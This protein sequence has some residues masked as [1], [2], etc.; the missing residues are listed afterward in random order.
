MGI[1][2]FKE[3]LTLQQTV[4]P[5]ERSKHVWVTDPRNRQQ[6]ASWERQRTTRVF[7][8]PLA[9]DR[10]VHFTLPESAAEIMASNRIDGPDGVYAVSLMWG[11]WVPVVQFN[12]IVGKKQKLLQPHMLRDP[13]S[14]RRLQATGWRKPEY[15]KEVV[16]VVFRTAHLP[17]AARKEE[18]YWGG[19]VP[20]TDARQVAAREAIRMLQH[21]PYGRLVGEDDAVQYFSGAGEPS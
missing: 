9:R 12:H 15:G 17:Q 4:P 2:R 10:F 1:T 3:W 19:P 14:S 7:S 8:F 6:V 21:A 5:D 18:V 20:I 13:E 11:A 16:G